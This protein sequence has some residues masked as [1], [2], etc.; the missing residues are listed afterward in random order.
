MQNSRQY[1]SFSILSVSPLLSYF[2]IFLLKS[3]MSVLVFV[4][5]FFHVLVALIFNSVNYNVPK[6]GFIHI[7]PTD[8]L[9]NFWILNVQLDTLH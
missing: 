4:L 8:C 5:Y 1:I 9:C 7:C 2:Y 3:Q 6:Y